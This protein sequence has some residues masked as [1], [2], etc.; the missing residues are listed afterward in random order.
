MADFPTGPKEPKSTCLSL[1]DEAII[2]ALLPAYATAV[3]ASMHF[4]RRSRI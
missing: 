4:K 2:V 3:A 1:E